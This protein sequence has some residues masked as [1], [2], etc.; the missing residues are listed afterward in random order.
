[1]QIVDPPLWDNSLITFAI[2]N[3]VQA[4]VTKKLAITSASS[5]YGTWKCV[6][7]HSSF[8]GTYKKAKD[9]DDCNVCG[10]PLDQYHELVLLNE[11][12]KLS[13]SVDITLLID[14]L[15]Y[16]NEIK[17]IKREAWEELKRPQPLHLLQ[18]VFYWWMARELGMPLYREVSILYINKSFA[19]SSPYKEF[20]LRPEDHLHRLTDYIEDARALTV[21]RQG[22]KL[23]IRTCPEPGSS[24]AKKCNMRDVCFARD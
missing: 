12:L 1:M 24:I 21:S 16:L 14:G 23:P 13:G 11:D 22:G 5:L 3:S 18:V 7:G 10:K 8:V 2:G 20:Q 6:C 4:Y 15:F 9:E 17:S 19:F